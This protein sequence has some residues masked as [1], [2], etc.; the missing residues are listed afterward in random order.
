MYKQGQ[1]PK[2]NISKL[3]KNVNKEEWEM[4]A[5]L[6]NAYYHPLLNEIVFFAPEN[7]ANITLFGFP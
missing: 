5:H 7:Q 6:I 1:N 2:K 3:N 4:P